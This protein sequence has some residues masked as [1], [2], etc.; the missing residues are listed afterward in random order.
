MTGKNSF[1]E[2][3][4]RRHNFR[5]FKKESPDKDLNNLIDIKKKQFRIE[6]KPE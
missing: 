6:G 4:Q 3:L 5:Y 2:T 1:L